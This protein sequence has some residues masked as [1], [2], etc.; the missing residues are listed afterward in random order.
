MSWIAFVNWLCI[1][2][3]ELITTF[4]KDK[5]MMRTQKRY[6]DQISL[7]R[8]IPHLLGLMQLEFY[9]RIVQNKEIN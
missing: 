5:K 2:R 6:Y 8:Y 3:K 1:A 4:H 9:F 7:E